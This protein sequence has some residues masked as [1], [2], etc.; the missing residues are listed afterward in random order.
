MYLRLS[1]LKIWQR[2]GMIAATKEDVK[3]I[4]QMLAALCEKDLV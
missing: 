4:E 2:N 1:S 3:T